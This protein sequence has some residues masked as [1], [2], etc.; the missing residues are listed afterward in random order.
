MRL[1]HHFEGR[2]GVD[3]T[4]RR[5]IRVGEMTVHI[6]LEIVEPKPLATALETYGRRI[7]DIFLENPRIL[8]SGEKEG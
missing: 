6:R 3:D 5:T 7:V 2:I 8:Y 1:D 4:D